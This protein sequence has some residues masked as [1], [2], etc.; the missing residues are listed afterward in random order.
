MEE[1]KLER[2]SRRACDA[3]EWR[4]LVDTR[5]KVVGWFFLLQYESD[6]DEKE[7]IYFVIHR[8]DGCKQKK[9]RCQGFKGGDFAEQNTTRPLMPQKPYGK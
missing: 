8:Q 2:A 7:E 9:S 6:G 1:H 5:Y 3:T 4:G